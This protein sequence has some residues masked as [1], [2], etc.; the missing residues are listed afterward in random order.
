VNEQQQP[1]QDALAEA[2]EAFQRMTV[3]GVPPDAA[4]LARLDEELADKARHVIA[5]PSA[6]RSGFL[7]R[8][9]IPSAA[10]AVVVIG[11]MALL[12]LNAAASIALADVVRAAQKHKLVRYQEQRLTDTKEE[13]GAVLESMVYADFT[14]PRLYSESRIN[15]LNGECVLL[16]V[17]DGKHHLITNSR[18][19]TA[20]LALAPKGYKSLL[21]CL[22]DFEQ[23]KDVT[24]EKSD[25]DGRPAIKYRHVEGK[26]SILLWVDV[27]TRLPL[28]MEQEF[29]DPSPGITRSTLVWTDFAWDPELPP[30]IESVNQLF[31]TRPPDGYTLDDQTRSRNQ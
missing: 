11:G 17:H 21:C 22:E 20:R 3:P 10:A 5:P 8:L 1:T 16:S 28:R 18:Q 15:D 27:K 26:R 6:K 2:I 29:D 9:L 31:S 30:G 13:A 19:K 25:L 23:K 12:L 24:H 14:A 4:I 7:T